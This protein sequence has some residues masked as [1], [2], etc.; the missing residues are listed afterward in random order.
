MWDLGNGRKF[1][2]SSRPDRKP[3]AQVD[4]QHDPAAPDGTASP[5]LPD[6]RSFITGATRSGAAVT[7]DTQGILR[8]W[9]VATGEEVKTIMLERGWIKSAAFTRDGRQAVVA[10]KEVGLYDLETGEEVRVFLRPRR[11]FSRSCRG[12][13]RLLTGDFDGVVRLYDVRSGNLLR[14][15]GRHDEFIFSVAFSADGRLASVRRGRPRQP[16]LRRARLSSVSAP[17]LRL[18]CHCYT[19]NRPCWFQAKL[20]RR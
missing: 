8:L 20:D 11:T 14:E 10:D 19:P 16:Q 12:R 18:E 9:N 2:G 6:K 7:G 5:P 1:S 3:V 17:F 15:L 4:E 13:R